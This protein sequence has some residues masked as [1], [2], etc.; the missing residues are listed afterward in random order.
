[1]PKLD[2][3]LRVAEEKEFA[4]LTLEGSVLDLGGVGNAGYLRNIKGNHEVTSVNVDPATG[5]TLVH[6]LERTPLPLQ[7]ASFD[8]V[9]MNNTLEH[10]YHARELVA[11]AVRVLREGGIIIITVPCLFPI[12]P[13][14]RDYWRFTDDALRTMLAENGITQVTSKALGTGVCTVC[15]HLIER[16][17][18]RPLRILTYFLR[19]ISSLFDRIMYAFRRPGSV[20]KREYYT[21]GYFVTGTK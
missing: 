17:L 10:I 14:P 3:I 20:Q 11:E 9:I 5:C 12:H 21:L 4:S 1:M 19:P 18:P 2:S 7:S 13:S 8:V 6:D 15:H 16:L